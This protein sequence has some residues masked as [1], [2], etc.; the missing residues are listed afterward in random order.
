VP[1]AWVAVLWSLHNLV[2]VAASWFGGRLSDRVGRRALLIAGWVVY[3][4]VYLGF[5][6]VG[7]SAGLVVLFLVYGLSFGLA[8]PAERALVAD[9]APAHLRGSAFGYFH[10]AVAAAALPASAGFG[11]L[12]SA[13]GAPVAFASG[14]AL[15]ALAT[16]VL[17]TVRGEGSGTGTGTGTGKI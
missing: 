13:F 15:A 10:A 2:K 9:L 8:E 6:A 17:L 4:V 5:A 14:A 11:L 16:G 7:S 12:W 1:T 3:A